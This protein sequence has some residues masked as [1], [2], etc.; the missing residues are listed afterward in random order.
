M[1]GWMGKIIKI[2]LSSGKQDILKINDDDLRKYIG[3]RGLGV[4]LY[5]DLCPGN[6]EPLSPENKLIFLTGPLTGL[7]QTAGRYQVI[8]KS[9]LTGTIFDSSSGGVFGAV[10]KRTGFDGI[11]FSGKADKPV[12]LHITEDKA[13]LRDAMH[14]WGKNTH[15]TKELLLSETDNKGSVASIGPAGENMVPF[16]AIMNDKDRAAGRGGM[17]AIMGSKNLKAIVAYGKKEIPVHDPEKLKE[18]LKKWNT[19]ID[20]NPVTGKSLPL[21]G[22]SVLVNVINAHGM[23]PTRNFQSG[24]FNDAEGISGEKIAETLLTSGSACFRCPI[25]CGRTTKTK[26]K[27]GEGPEYESVWAFGAHLG[28]GDL[29]TATEA[30]YACNELGMD[31]ISTGG[32]IGCAMELSEKGAFPHEMKWGDTANLVQLVNDIANKEGIGAELALGSRELAKKY[33]MPE[34]SMTV[35]GLDIPAYDPRGVQG[36]ALSYA[37]SNRG[38]CH[39]RAYAVAPEILGSP[40]FLDRYSTEGKEE[41]VALLQDVSAAVDCLVLCRFLQFAVS[42]TSF[43]EML[44]AVTG[45]NYTDEELLEVGRRV[46]NLE[47]KINCEA[48]LGKADDMLPSRF[49]NEELKEGASRNRVV[50]LDKMLNDYYKLRGWDEQGIPTQKTLDE[51]GI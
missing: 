50:Q 16:A 3:A 38:G 13:E 21:L 47:R 44:N 7:V 1:K 6:I 26:N 51:L 19:L 15:E 37:T 20:K 2:D 45:M 41:I 9:P 35:K 32:V 36:Q 27:S 12:Y 42:L 17:G 33:K 29:E 8:S 4:K 46:Y 10:L 23:F 43:T 31:T 18:L 5:H 39:M 28:S 25:A 14:I 40:V 22:T 34:L 49:L 24:N 30:N 48:G 11:I